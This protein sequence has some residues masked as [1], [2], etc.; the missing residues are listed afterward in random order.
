MNRRSLLREQLIEA[1][2]TTI[3]HQYRGQLINSER[4]LQVYFCAALLGAFERKGLKRRLFV[5]PRLAADAERRYPDVV[6]CNTRSI[7]RHVIK[8]LSDTR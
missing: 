7:I 3:E 1:W 2:W 5:E 4:G 8:G 6:I